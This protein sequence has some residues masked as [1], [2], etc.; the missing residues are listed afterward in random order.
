MKKKHWRAYVD[1]NGESHLEE[2][3]VDLL[4]SDYAPP[5]PALFVSAPGPAAGCGYLA[6][7]PGWDGG[8]HPSPRRQLFVLLHGIL[9]GEV[10]DGRSVRLRPGDVILLEDLSGKG[11][12]S[13]VVGDEKVEALV[14]VLP[15]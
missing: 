15:D 8:W 7:A 9:E 1:A 14:V 2:V 5:A 13:R 4:L 3:D 11:H 12:A 6:A 10:S